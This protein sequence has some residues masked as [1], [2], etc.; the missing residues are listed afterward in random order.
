MLADALPIHRLALF[1]VF[2]VTTG[3]QLL[4][5]G[6]T[7]PAAELTLAGGAR[8]KQ[9]GSAESPAKVTSDTTTTT[10]PVPAGSTVTTDEKKPGIV[11]VTLAGQTEIK[12]EARKETAEA[13]KAFTPPAP[14]SPSEIAT[15]RAAGWFWAGICGGVAGG[16]FG[17]V[18]GWDLLMYGG[19]AI[20]AGCALGLFVQQ[21]P[22]VLVLIGCGVA[23][24]VIGPT[25]W[26][27]KLKHLEP[28][29]P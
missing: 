19:A 2:L 7:A 18:R 13:P 16:L 29:S 15:A 22:L 23:A 8:L 3:C 10:V 28:K 26:H 21:H 11:T 25:L 1:L 9:N 14:P 27:L 24:A 4:P 6:V 12:T 17:L 5:R 20:A